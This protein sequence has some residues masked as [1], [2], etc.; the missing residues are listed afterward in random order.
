MAGHPPARAAVEPP[1]LTEP[2]TL[3]TPRLLLRP[4]RDSDL[5][6]FAALNTDAEVMRHF[7]EPLSRA[8]SDAL[9]QRSRALIEARGWGFWAVERRDNG[10]FAGFLGLH[11]P[12][13]DLPFAP[14]VEIGWRLARAHWGQGLATEGARA[15]L[16]FGFEQLGLPEIVAFTALGNTRSEAVMQRLGMRRD[17]ATF[18]H[19]ALAPGHPLREHV[20]YR[21]R[22]PVH[23]ASTK[24]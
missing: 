23:G 22:R 6:P 5:A 16:D 18:G 24:T 11:T 17:A 21:L 15:A 14:C 20:L 7:P 9:A 3:R 8:Q 13:T 10:A 12:S 19:P 1:H 2:V 4:W